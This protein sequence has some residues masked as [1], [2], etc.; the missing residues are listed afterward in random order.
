MFPAEA[1]IAVQKAQR[2]Q[3][4][5]QPKPQRDDIVAISYEV[6]VG[7]FATWRNPRE[8]TIHRQL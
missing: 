8:P 1:A 7:A 6:S 3:T 5:Y 4:R 2:K